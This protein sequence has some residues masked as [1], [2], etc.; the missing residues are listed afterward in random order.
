MPDTKE[1][2]TVR[3]PTM[4]CLWTDGETLSTCHIT[5]LNGFRCLGG[6]AERAAC[7]MWNR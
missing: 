4:I 3:D 1:I 5:W 6:A 2:T 7:P